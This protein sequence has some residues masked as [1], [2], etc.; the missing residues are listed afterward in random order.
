MVGKA[1]NQTPAIHPSKAVNKYKMSEVTSPTRRSLLWIL[2]AAPFGCPGYS[3]A[4]AQASQAGPA[5]HKF[6]DKV[7]MSYE[8]MFRFAYEDVI[9]TLKKLARQVGRERLLELLMAPDEPRARKPRIREPEFKDFLAVR[10]RPDP[11]SNHANT[12]V[13][14]QETKNSLQYKTTECLWAKVFREADAADIGYAWVCHPDFANAR[15]WSSKMK[16]VRTKTLMQGHE[17]CDFR[18]EWKD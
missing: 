16:L 11:L 18:W 12:R 13:E 5:K 14:W 8:E 7:D 6:Q 9:S 17:H 15:R 2:P 3:F 10:K 1:K 4:E